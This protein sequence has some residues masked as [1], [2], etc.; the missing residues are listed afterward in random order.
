MVLRWFNLQYRATNFLGYFEGI[1]ENLRLMPV[2]YPGWIMRLYHDVENEDPVM[3]VG[4]KYI[5]C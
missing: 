5:F 3:K 2:Y 4:F 1:A